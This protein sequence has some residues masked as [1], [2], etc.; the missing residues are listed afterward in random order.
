M[1]I[2]SLPLLTL[3]F[4]LLFQTTAEA[5]NKGISNAQLKRAKLHWSHFQDAGK[6]YRLDP[7]LLLAISLHESSCRVTAI[8]KK[9]RNKSIDVG[10]MQV[11]SWWFPQVKKYTP[12]LNN[13]YDPR[14]NIH[15]GAW[16]FKQCTNRFSNTAQAIDCYNKG[17]P[18][19]KKTSTYARGV[20]N[21]YNKVKKINIH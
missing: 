8:N 7:K 10:L 5:K 13:L 14:F 15:V 9:N 19:A 21:K 17:A 1:K 6:R 20:L 18:R 16:I 2:S 12:N 4:F 3:S 11:N